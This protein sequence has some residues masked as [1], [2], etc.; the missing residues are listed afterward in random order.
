MC[1]SALV[2]QKL[3]S[4]S[5]TYQAR[6]QID[7]FEELFKSRLEGSG[8]KISRAL[9]HDFL[10]GTKTMQEKRIATSIRDFR[11][12]ELEKLSSDL[13]AQKKRLSVS[14]KTLLTKVTKKAQKNQRIATDKIEAIQRRIER[15]TSNELNESDSRI[16]PGQY[17]PLI[18][19]LNSEKVIAPFRYLLRPK[20]QTPEFDRRYNGAY[21]IRRDSLQKVF[22][23][24]SIYGRHHGFMEIKSF[25]ENVKLHDF[26][27]RELKK[28]EEEKN[29]I[30]RF[31]PD[32]LDHMIIPCLFDFNTEGEFPLQSF[33]LIT[34]EP[35]PEV[36]AVGHDRTPVIMK[37]KYIDLWLN[38]SHGNLAS[39]DLTRYLPIFEDKQA[40]FLEHRVAA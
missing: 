19:Q 30:L 25:W 33:A 4:L 6:V 23:W 9:E 11:K 34:D 14:E 32:G 3:K 10:S 37:E 7:L 29:I 21:N 16:Y 18:T 26:E 12:S 36:A 17:A 13:V 8:A 28:G 38:T 1:Y 2:N 5:I 40:S 15:L 27:N 31:D 39:G 35:N 20:G 22:W 24:K